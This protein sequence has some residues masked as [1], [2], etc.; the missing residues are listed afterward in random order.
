MKSPKIKSKSIYLIKE[1]KI[2]DGFPISSGMYFNIS[3]IDNDGKMNLV[4]IK[5]GFIYNY[6]INN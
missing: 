3:D 6:E 2:V 1:N 4:S 5:K